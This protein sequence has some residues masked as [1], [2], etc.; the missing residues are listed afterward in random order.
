[1]M[2]LD[3]FY[4]INH[5][6][7]IAPQHYRVSVTLEPEHPVYTGHFPETPVVPGVCSLQMIIECTGKVLGY[8][9]AMIQASVVKFLQIMRPTFDRELVIDI[10]LNDELIVKAAIL[11]GER[12]VASC[13]MKM[14]K[15]EDIWN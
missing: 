3:T 1:M 11:S 9:V 2:L 6:E 12:N 10:Q 5:L 8:P 13:K 7:S 4:Y 14:K 15:F